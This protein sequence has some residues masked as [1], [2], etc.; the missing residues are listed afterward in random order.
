[1]PFCRLFNVASDRFSRCAS[2][3]VRER[4]RF[5]GTWGRPASVFVDDVRHSFGRMVM[6]NMWADTEAELLAMADTVSVQRKWIQR[7]PTLSFGKHRA[8]S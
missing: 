4:T 7:H 1:M 3:T 5:V 6:C 2:L 8:A